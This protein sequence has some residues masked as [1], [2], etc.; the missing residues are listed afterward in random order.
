MFEEQDTSTGGTEVDAAAVGVWVDRLAEALPTGEDSGAALVEEITALERLKSAAAARQARLTAAFDTAQRTAQRAAGM[1]AERVGRG[2]GAQIGLARHDSPQKGVRYVGLA[3]TLLGEM[4]QTL[5]ALQRGECSEWRAMIM[6]RETACLSLQH[7]RAV[8]AALGPRLANLGDQQVWSQARAEAYRLDPESAVR[9]VRG[10]QSDR[11]VSIRPAPDAMAHLTGFLPVKQAVAAYAALKKHVDAATA[12]GDERSRGQIMADEFANRLAGIS[13]AAEIGAEIQLVV[14]A[15]ALFAPPTGYPPTQDTTTDDAP[16]AHESTHEPADDA[17][18]GYEPTTGGDS[19]AE[20]GW[21]HGYG[22][23]PAA[24]VRELVRDSTARIWLRRLFTR[25]TDGALVA[26][27]AKGRLFPKQLR[28]L[29]VVR[30]QTCRTPWCGAPIRHADHVEAHV[31]GGA[32][33]FSNG[34][35]LCVACNVSKRAPGWHARPAPES[36]ADTIELITPTGMVYYSEAPPIPGR[37]RRWLARR[38]LHRRGP[39]ESDSYLEDAFEA[40]LAAS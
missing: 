1:R 20:P 6:A 25:P 17:P 26:M 8:D 10:A 35:G 24:W 34:Q 19:G 40:L 31:E 3:K 33:T 16:V 9:R 38:R 37:R 7:R 13:H 4:P 14:D 29:L 39:R 23:V 22:P 28:Q 36:G 30:D 21:L 11:R 27:E 2:I 18:V 5:A 32:T 12:A 15:D